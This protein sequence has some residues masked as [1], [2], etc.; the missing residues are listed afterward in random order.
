MEDRTSKMS[1]RP[2]S[3]PIKPKRDGEPLAELTG[4]DRLVSNVVFSWVAHSV[5]IVSGFIMPRMI[6]RQLGQDLLGVWDFGWS[7]VSYFSL[8][9]VGIGGS[10]NRYVAKYRV[11]GDISGV[12]RV[13]S[14]VFCFQSVAGLL[15]VGLAIAV[16]WL[17]PH[18]FGARLGEN[19]L[20]AQRV[21]FL[22]G[23]SLGIQI[24]LASF[25]GVLTG[26]HRWEL[27][28]VVKSGWHVA[29]VIGMIV[30][31]LQGKGLVALAMT[32]LVGLLLADLTRVILAHQ[33][34]KGLRVRLSLVRWGT[35]RRMF[36]F[37]AK[38]LIPSVS[39]LL[40]N[41]TTSILIVV[42]L[43]PSALALYARPRSLVRHLYT[44]VHKMAM[45]LTPIASSMQSVDNM[46]AI[47]DLLIKSVR[48]SLY[49]ALPMVTVVVV[50]G[51]PILRLWMGPRYANDLVPAI[52]AIGY[53]TTIS[54]I[55]VMMILVGINSH[56][57]AGMAHLVASLCSVG[58][59]V[60][61]LRYLRWGIVGAAVAVTFPLTIMNVVYLPSLICRRV[62]L[63]VGGYL[64]SVAAGPV[65]HVFPFA[66]CL[67]TA[68]I[69]FQSEPL[70]GLAWGGCGGAALLA[71]IYWRCVL[72]DRM[73]AK[74]LRCLQMGG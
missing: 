43:G 26:C 19:V 50:F 40:L 2:Q 61:A 1:D 6:D 41:Q 55:A 67:V 56:G 21:V 28:N 51:G 10:V 17:L 47:R 44:L 52:L 29:T 45:T 5:F 68:R 71:A 3:L 4:R 59:T 46:E 35:I 53:L 25:I 64:L 38:A 13:V 60:L 9:Q 37:G 72:P 66:V 15:I 73:R 11:S 32:N 34:C 8:V 70:V 27:H 14:S 58:L 20:A 24:S 12:N 57:R 42:Y 36:V 63:A 18:L 48:Y 22:L 74:I 39:N 30:A 16:S 49:M 54:Q 62:E 31:L 65:L 23:A 7:L 69:H 33:I